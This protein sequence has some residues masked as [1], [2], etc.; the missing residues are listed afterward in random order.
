MCISHYYSIK[1]IHISLQL[2]DCIIFEGDIG[3]FDF[4]IF[5]LKSLYVQ[6]LLLFKFQNFACLLI[7]YVGRPTFLCQ[8]QPLICCKPFL[9]LSW[10]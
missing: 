10:I 9:V 3:L 8:K 2:V 1:H 5:H 7:A 6:L 4:R